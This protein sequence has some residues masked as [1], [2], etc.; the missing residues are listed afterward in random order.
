MGRRYLAEFLGTWAIVFFG[1]GAMATL[2]GDPAA[3][4]M[5]NLVF[6]LTVAAAIYALGH[7]SAAHFNPAVT[8]AFAVAGRFPGRF[9][10]PYIASQF[11]GAV[12]AS[13][14]HSF[15]FGAK[16]V[17]AKFGATVPGGP[18]GSVFGIEVALTFFLMLVIISVA[19][20]RR[21]N[22][23]IPGL[24]IGAAVTLCGL[25]GGPISG[26]SMNPARSLGPAIFAG[27]S[28]MASWWIYG[29]APVVGAILAA[30]VYEVIRGGDEH[31]M[32][33]PNDLDN[34]LRRIDQI[35]A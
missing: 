32:G 17:G 11:A 4:L 22:G 19:T 7:I 14:L 12:V 15:F 30:R 33:A 8:V 21:A 6:G 27:G 31:G 18:V 34:A 5:V 26:C 2:A 23:A 24:A 13:G 3:H 9:V 10:L 20:D 29:L 1:C 28:P 16:A 25:M 35:P